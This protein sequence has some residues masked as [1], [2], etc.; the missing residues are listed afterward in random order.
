M[1]LSGALRFKIEQT[2]KLF[3]S[4]RPLCIHHRKPQYLAD[5][6]RLA[7]ELLEEAKDA[8]KERRAVKGG[9]C[10]K[11]GSLCVCRYVPIPERIMEYMENNLCGLTDIRH[12]PCYVVQTIYN[13]YP[14]ADHIPGMIQ[15]PIL[16]QK[17]HDKETTAERNERGKRYKKNKKGVRHQASST[18]N[19]GLSRPF[20]GSCRLKRCFHH[21]R[22]HFVP[23]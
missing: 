7:F 6:F 8:L 9:Y 14:V 12:V 1:I 11:Y 19:L 10:F 21:V 18:G 20:I 13:L 16:P 2:D 4:P 17:K 23:T 3:S 22:Q 5:G 15:P